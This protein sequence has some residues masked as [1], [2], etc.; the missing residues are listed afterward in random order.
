MRN[1]DFT[2]LSCAIATV[3]TTIPAAT[4]AVAALRANVRPC[5]IANWNTDAFNTLN[6][7]RSEA[8]NMENEK[9]VIRYYGKSELAML[10]FPDDNKE[11]ALYKLRIELKL[12]PNLRHL[13]SKNARRYS[14]K[15][16]KQI[17]A[18][19]GI[20]G[21]YEGIDHLVLGLPA[22]PAATPLPR[23]ADYVRWAE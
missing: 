15:D 8:L 11:N 14:P 7:L 9:F 20:E 19:L 23:K 22:K 1:V 16:V 21:N 10:Y 12:N 4:T 5:A 2:A 6:S 3:T 17:L 13:V 18:D